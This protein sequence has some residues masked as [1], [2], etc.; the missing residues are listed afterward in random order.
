[1]RGRKP[2][3]T[4][5]KLLTGNPGKR[6]LNLREP[7]LEPGVPDRPSHLGPEACAEWDRVSAVL[8]VQGII[9]QADRAALAA[10]CVAWGRWVE[11]E[12]KVKE[13]GA[14]VKAPRTGVPMQNPFLSI[15]NNAMAQM[16]KLAAEFGMTPSS[17]TRLEGLPSQWDSDSR[18]EQS[19]ADK[20]FA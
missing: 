6:P 5:L 8:Q 10:Y 12:R 20:Y 9:T 14:V 4:A 16:I 1:M 17:R 2:K 3:P 11:A 7:N 13:M 18:R 15:A 19:L